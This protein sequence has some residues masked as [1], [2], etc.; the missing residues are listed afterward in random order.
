MK[1]YPVSV[2]TC[3][4]YYPAVQIRGETSASSWTK[5]VDA[6]LTEIAKVCGITWETARLV[7]EELVEA[8]VVKSR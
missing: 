1:I 3:L 8:G 2:V 4:R 7:D 5:K 6:Y